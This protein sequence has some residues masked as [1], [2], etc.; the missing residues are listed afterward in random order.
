[1]LIFAH[2]SQ[3]SILNFEGVSTTLKDSTYVF[4]YALLLI[5]NTNT[6]ESSNHLHA[7]SMP[8]IYTAKYQN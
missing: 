1:M 3:I 8:T 5:Y 2:W 6:L 4:I 7:S